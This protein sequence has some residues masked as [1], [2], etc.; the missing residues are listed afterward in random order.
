[1][2]TRTTARRDQ[3]ETI[4]SVLGDAVRPRAK[5]LGGSVALLWTV[6][7]VDT[8]VGHGLDV[9]GVRPR[10]LEGLWGILFAPFL[11]GSWGHLI[12]N[13]VSLVMIGWLVMLG[14]TRDFLYV[15]ALSALTAGLGTWLVGGSNTVHVG[16]S[17]VVFGLLG[18]LLSRGVFERKF[19]SIAG[20]VLALVLFG[21]T[22][23]GLFPG[24]AG[25]SWEGH[26]FGFLGGILSAR[27]M[28]TPSVEAERGKAPARE[29]KRVGEAPPRARV[30]GRALEAVSDDEI[31]EL[32]RRMG[33]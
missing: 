6:N 7:L 32:R 29:K 1:M 14:R 33:R 16:A 26:L 9:W 2:P 8:V 4:S 15:S 30:A 31:E 17:G 13:T 24:T 3:P 10:T 25:I 28:A 19:W 5:L 27:L 18:Y 23:R 20:S 21:G 11:H 12:A 22:L